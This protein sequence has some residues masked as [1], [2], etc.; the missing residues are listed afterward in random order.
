MTD[1]SASDQTP[2]EHL[3]VALRHSEAALRSVEQEILTAP[4]ARCAALIA[5][6]DHYALIVEETREALRRTL[7]E[8]TRRWPP[9]S[10]SG[11]S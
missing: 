4:E 1:R 11:R 8:E 3:A 9:Q 2:A 6:A 7:E 5:L 10:S